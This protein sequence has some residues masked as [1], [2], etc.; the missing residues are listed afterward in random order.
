MSAGHNANNERYASQ[1]VLMFNNK[2]R[3]A[4]SPMLRK[5]ISR[6]LIA[7]FRSS[8]LLTPET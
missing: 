4:T 8:S 5:A 6:L 7:F 3:Q 2:K 1:A